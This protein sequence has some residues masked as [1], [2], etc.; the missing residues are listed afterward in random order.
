VL[1]D[2]ETEYRHRDGT[3]YADTKTA[4]SR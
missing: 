1:K 4:R 3:P 2:G